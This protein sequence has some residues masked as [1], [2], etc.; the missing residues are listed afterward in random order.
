MPQRPDGYKRLMINL[1]AQGLTETCAARIADNPVLISALFAIMVPH[2]PPKRSVYSDDHSPVVD[3]GV[4]YTW[5]EFLDQDISALSPMGPGPYDTRT[6]NALRAA[7]IHSV[8]GLLTR[9]P[10]EVSDVRHLGGPSLDHLNERLGTLGVRL[11]EE[12]HQHKGFLKAAAG[13][14]VRPDV[15]LDLRTSEL[16]FPKLLWRQFP[17]MRSIVEGDAHVALSRLESKSA[18]YRN[19]ARTLVRFLLEYLRTQAEHP[20]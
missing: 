1:R 5:Q 3:G 6:G 11:L 19:F 12:N 14:Y 4:V 15:L 17:T 7:D 10:T 2:E 13:W 16:G 18:G 8:R 9:T 20:Q